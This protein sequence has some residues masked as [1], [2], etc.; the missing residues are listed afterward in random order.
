[1]LDRAAEH[2]RE[3]GAVERVAVAALGQQLGAPTGDQQKA[4]EQAVSELDRGEVV[5]QLGL[6]DVPDQRDVRVGGA[7][8]L[9]YEL[10]APCGC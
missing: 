9:W 1:V 4:V 10:S 6:G 5:A 3:A 2:A 7:R 8:Y